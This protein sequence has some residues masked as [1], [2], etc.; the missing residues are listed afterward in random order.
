MPHQFHSHIACRDHALRVSERSEAAAA[1][2]HLTSV[3]PA[4]LPILRL[5]CRLQRASEAKDSL[6]AAANAAAHKRAHNARSVETSR[7]FDRTTSTTDSY[8]VPCSYTLRRRNAHTGTPVKAE[9]KS[10]ATTDSLKDFSANAYAILHT[11]PGAHPLL[12]SVVAFIETELIVSSQTPERSAG[13]ATSDT[14][15]RTGFRRP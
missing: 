8:G 11:P 1:A 10:R 4:V 15:F 14:T 3:S 13:N 6:L 5:L 12:P 7:L 9:A 2:L